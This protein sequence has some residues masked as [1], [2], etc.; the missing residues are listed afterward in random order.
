MAPLTA[1]APG[2]AG[3]ALADPRV[4]VQVIADGVH[5]ADDTLQLVVSAARGRWSIVSDAT[6]ASGQ[7]D[8]ELVLGEVPVVAAGGVVRRADGTIAGS[9]AKLLDGVRH[10][11]GLGVPLGEILTAATARPAALLGREEI[12]RIRLGDPA[13]LV[14]LG[15]E[16]EVDTVIVGGRSI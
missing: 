4:T 6:A 12:G 1:R 7:G 11:A 3:A 10:L 2:L 13:Y 9:A 15:D 14:L 8:G 16:L 5:L